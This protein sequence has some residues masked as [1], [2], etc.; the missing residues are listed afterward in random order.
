MNLNSLKKSKRN[1]QD[2]GIA[3]LTTILL[4]FLM[5]SLL[6]GFAVLLL[7][8]QQL[9]G[10]NN[11]QVTAFYAAE[12]G[13]EQMTASLGALFSQT[14]SPSILQINTLESTPPSSTIFPGIT[15]MTA[16]GNPGYT[17]TPLALDKNGNPAP[18]ITT[19]KAGT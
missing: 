5:S 10:A 19:I 17:I 9:A 13:M 3:L 8:N 14:Y 18:T 2:A 7:S 1:R 15:Y 11:D 16:D 6:V 4:L 12:A